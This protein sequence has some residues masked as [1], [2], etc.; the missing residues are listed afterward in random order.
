MEIKD[1]SRSNAEHTQTAHSESSID[2][3]FSHH[4]SH[5]TAINAALSEVENQCLFICSVIAYAHGNIV[6][7]VGKQ[8]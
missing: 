3:S 1:G 8:K 4:R 6:Q 2:C 7:F 5:E